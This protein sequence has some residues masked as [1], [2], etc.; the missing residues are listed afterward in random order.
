M[1]VALPLPMTPPV[2]V[3]SPT[4]AS[5]NPLAKVF[6]E[7]VTTQELQLAT[8]SS[9]EPLRLLWAL[10][11]KACKTDP[12]QRFGKAREILNALSAEQKPSRAPKPQPPKKCQRFWDFLFFWRWLDRVDGFRCHLGPVDVR[13][14]Q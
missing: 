9:D 5:G 14:T 4:R 13:A 2:V 1:T 12:A 10:I 7:P 8:M 11:Q 6:G 3:W